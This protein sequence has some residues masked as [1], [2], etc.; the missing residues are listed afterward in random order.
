MSSESTGPDVEVVILLASAGGLSALCAVLA[1]LPTDFPA[2]VVV[3]QHLG[4]HTSVLP[5]I[6]SRRTGHEAHWA[7]DGERLVSHGVTVCPPEMYMELAPGG[8]C[9]LREAGPR[10]ER[11]FDVTLASAGACYGPRALAVVL[12]GSGR[13]GAAGTVELKRAGGSVIAQSKETAQYPSMP[14]AAAEGGAVV[15][16][17]DD[18]GR[19]LVEVVRNPQPGP[20]RIDAA[21]RKLG[22]SPRHNIAENPTLPDNHSGDVDDPGVRGALARRRA[23]ELQ[24]RREELAS[25]SRSTADSVATARSRAREAA[26]RAEDARQVAARHIAALRKPD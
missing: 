16:P 26:R 7:A 19:V 1:N 23:A 15:L 10:R 25:G 9:A 22:I 18:I 5:T 6:L 3:Q 21:L 20:A 2:A 8:T 4:G 13:D 12:S 17:L 14:M 11:R 24:R